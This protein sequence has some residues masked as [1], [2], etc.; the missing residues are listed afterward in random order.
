MIPGCPRFV[1]ALVLGAIAATSPGPAQGQD[2]QP[3]SQLP[4]LPNGVVLGEAV[5]AYNEGTLTDPRWARWRSIY[6][7]FDGFIVEPAD[8]E[9]TRV[10]L[11][12]RLTGGWLGVG[13]RPGDGEA[14]DLAVYSLMG[15]LPPHLDR[16]DGVVPPDSVA[17]AVRRYLTVVSDSGLFSGAIV[18]ARGDEVLVAE[19]HGWAREETERNGPST[20]FSLASVGKVFTAVAVLQ[21]A[22]RGR[23]SLTDTVGEYM[24][25]YPYASVRRARIGQL[26]THTSGAG[27]ASFDWIADR[28]DRTLEEL[29]AVTASPPLFEPGEGVRYS[30]E[31]FLLAGRIVEVVSGLAYEEYLRRHIFEPAGMVGSG[32]WPWAELNSGVAVPYASWGREGDR[33]V[34]RPGPRRSALPLHGFR[35]SPAGGAFSTA[36]DLHRFSVALLR[37][38]LLGEGTL[39]QLFEPQVVQPPPFFSFGYGVEMATAGGTPRVGK[40]GAAQGVSA[41]WR[42]YPST[43]YTLIVLSN[44][45]GIAPVVAARIEELITP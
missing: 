28:T 33:E 16:K 1:L 17:E 34:Y 32:V 26:L 13:A 24:P 3:L 22:E 44:F 14:A 40:G 27:R 11:H 35:G 25:E 6:G 42:V 30:N 8:G 29:V 38:A 12:G 21:L 45:D 43:G 9:E 18:L 23:L 2:H 10:W 5:H 19:G 31:A 15:E 37:G 4:G 7:P 39:R 41:A 36:V 20:M